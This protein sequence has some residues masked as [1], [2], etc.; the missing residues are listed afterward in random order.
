MHW[1]FSISDRYLICDKLII[2]C[3]FV[4]HLDIHIDVVVLFFVANI[5]LVND[6]F[7]LLREFIFDSF[8]NL[9][10][11][12]FDGKLVF[13]NILADIFVYD[14]LSYIFLVVPG[15][16]FLYDSPHINRFIDVF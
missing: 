11:Q 5:V 4:F 9:N 13:H 2:Y 3:I 12:C 7:Q 16:I 6:L 10:I 14:F 15:D 1:R 8:A